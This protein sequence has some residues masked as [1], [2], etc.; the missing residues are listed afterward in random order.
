MLATSRRFSAGRNLETAM[1][2]LV[3]AWRHG[4]PLVTGTDSG[5]PLAFHGPGVHRE[6][7]LWVQAGIPPAV[8]L[9]AATDNAALLLHAGGRIGL[10]KKGYQATFILVDGDPLKDIGATERISAI[11]YKG[12]HIRRWA[13][14]DDEKEK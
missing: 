2:N 5:V 10:I 7:Q 13:L 11:F 4:V 14:F 9:Q 3:E 8:A 6:L 12:E 1:A